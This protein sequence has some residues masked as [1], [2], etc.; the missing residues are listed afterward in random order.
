M[1]PS[2][3]TPLSITT[4]SANGAA[5]D[6]IDNYGSSI[7]TIS[8]FAN[9]I[10]LIPFTIKELTNVAKLFIFCSANATGNFDIG[11]YMSDGTKIVTTGS[12]ARTATNDLQI[13]DV[14]DT[15]L[16]AGSYYFALV[17]DNATATY[18]AISGLTAGVEPSVVGMATHSSTTFPLPATITV[19]SF[20]TTVVPIL[21][22]ST[23]PLI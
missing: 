6:C 7:G 11:I 18:E 14:S 10:R 3:P 15:I 22:F 13:V 17:T 16:P 2:L 23:T 4:A 21:G 12:V 8:L 19:S 20:S 5:A 9:T 1:N